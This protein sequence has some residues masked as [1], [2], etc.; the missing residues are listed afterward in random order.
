M[1]SEFWGYLP[2]SFKGY[3]IF[4]QINKG[5]WDTGTPIPGSHLYTGKYRH[6]M[7]ENR[8]SNIRWRNPTHS[9]MYTLIYYSLVTVNKD[10]IH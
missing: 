6:H 2:Y 7:S 3:G 1:L 4:F 10:S 5:I 9:T 8:Y